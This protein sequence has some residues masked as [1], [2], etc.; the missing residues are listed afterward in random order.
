MCKK[1][2]LEEIATKKE[3]AT[4]ED[5]VGKDGRDCHQGRS[6]LYE[7]ATASLSAYLSYRCVAIA[8]A[9][10]FLIASINLNG[11]SDPSN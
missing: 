10:I 7:F 8:F 2:T 1:P 4:K 6:K 3:A 5:T 11:H 9:L